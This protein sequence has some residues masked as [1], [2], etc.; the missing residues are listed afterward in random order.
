VKKVVGGSNANP[1]QTWSNMG[2]PRTLNKEQEKL[3]QA[4]A[5]PLQTDARLLEENGAYEV[6][7]TIAC[8]HLCMLEITPVN[9]ETESYLGFDPEEFYGME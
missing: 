9:D 3:L 4:A 1:M 8:N 7:L 2:K 6:E 5:E